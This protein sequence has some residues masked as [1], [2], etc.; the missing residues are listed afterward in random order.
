MGKQT[1]FLEFTRELPSKRLPEQRVGDYKEFTERYSDEKLR[2]MIEP[3]FI[4]RSIIR[5]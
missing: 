4:K 3:G 1:G 5:I 2:I